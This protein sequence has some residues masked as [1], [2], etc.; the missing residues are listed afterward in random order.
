M[1][2]TLALQSKVGTRKQLLKEQTKGTDSVVV[3]EGL[4]YRCLII[5]A[6]T[7]EHSTPEEVCH[8]SCEGGIVFL[9]AVG[10]RAS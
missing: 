7:Q 1:L 2:G 3:E 9:L 6:N 5:W 8:H 4:E 10:V